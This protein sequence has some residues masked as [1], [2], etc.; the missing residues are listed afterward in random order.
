MTEALHVLRIYVEANAVADGAPYWKVLLDRA[1]ATGVSSAAALRMLEAFGPAALV[2][3][4]KATKVTPGE[5]VILELV[6]DEPILL[7]FLETLPTTDEASLA[8]LESV[9]IARYGG[10]RH[11]GAAKGPRPDTEDSP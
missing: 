1:R 4:A 7:E 3:E 5:V 2:H 8:T 10:H 6:D 9:T 11:H